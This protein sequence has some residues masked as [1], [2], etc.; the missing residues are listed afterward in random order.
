MRCISLKPSS[1]SVPSRTSSTGACIRIRSTRPPGCAA[2]RPSFSQGCALASTTRFSCDA[3]FYDAEHNKL[4]VF[5][6]NN[7]DL[8]ALTVTQLYS[9]RWQVEVFF[10][11]IK[12]HLRIKAFCKS[13]HMCRPRFSRARGCVAIPPGIGLYPIVESAGQIVDY[14]QISNQTPT[15]RVAA[16]AHAEIRVD[17]KPARMNLLCVGKA[18]PLARSGFGSG[19]AGFPVMSPLMVG[20]IATG[21]VAPGLVPAPG[22]PGAQASARSDCRHT[23]PVNRNAILRGIN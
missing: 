13:V 3:S 23:A 5:L 15:P 21:A 4:L 7:F 11:W 20:A 1:S 8:P 17:E 16:D 2:I 12:R 9:C 22:T 18:A 19:E 14:S 6:T 10:E